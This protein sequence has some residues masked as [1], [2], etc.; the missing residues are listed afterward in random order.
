MWSYGLPE[1]SDEYRNNINKSNLIAVPGCY[2]TG[3]NLI[4][5][6]L[7]KTGLISCSHQFIIQAVSGFSGGGKNLIEYQIS[8]GINALVSVGTTGESATVDVESI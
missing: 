4:I 5:F 6:P 7:T 2:A 3:S 1:L 8:E